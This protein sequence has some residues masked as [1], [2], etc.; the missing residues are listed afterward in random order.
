MG[1]THPIA[2]TLAVPEL[3]F[4]VEWFPRAPAV[5]MCASVSGLIALRHVGLQ[6]P[7][8]FSF[9]KNTEFNTHTRC[10][11]PIAF[12]RGSSDR[13]FIVWK[14]PRASA[15]RSVCGV[16]IATSNKVPPIGTPYSSSLISCESVTISILKNSQVAPLSSLMGMSEICPSIGVLIDL[17]NPTNVEYFLR[18]SLKKR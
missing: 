16:S 17:Q 1:W 13:Q 2:I 12:E 10:P 14:S 3:H 8:G 9:R 15:S 11:G 7:Q 18:N 4:K 5:R 6:A